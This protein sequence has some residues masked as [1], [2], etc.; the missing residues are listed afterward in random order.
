MSNDILVKA[1]TTDGYMRIYAVDS[2]EAL[3]KAREIHDLS[4]VA[5]A[6]LGRCMSAGFMMGAMLKG[7]DDSI[8]ISFKG[9]G[10]IG[11]VLV[12]AKPDGTLKGYVDNPCVDLPLRADGKLDVGG[13]IGK[14]GY[15]SVIKDL[16][17]KNPYIGR[18][19]IQTGEIGDDLV[20]YF[21]KS[22]QVPSVVGLGV[23]VDGTSIIRRSGGFIVQVMP[24]CPEEAL[25]KL[26]NRIAT[27]SSVTD[28]LEKGMSA[29]DIIRYVMQDFEIDILE[30]VP[31]EY[32]CDCSRERMQGAIAS[33]GRKEIQAII[34]EQE[35]A[36]VACHFCNTKHTFCKEELEMMIKE[37]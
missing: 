37:K 6:A 1:V 21:M 9:G 2:R 10:E 20:F 16:N 12:V 8:T 24:D 33:L 34:D 4:P 19:P 25:V 5:A 7:K 17:L 13:A 31:V 30:S 27:V 3:L 32:R 14:D 36:E 26:E 23:L 35:S 11:G 22:E 15:L 18:V 28:M 29:E